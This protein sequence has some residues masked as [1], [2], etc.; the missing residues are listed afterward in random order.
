M[1]AIAMPNAVR[2]SSTATREHGAKP[3]P[4][5]DRDGIP[6]H[7]HGHPPGEGDALR[8][9]P[10]HRRTSTATPGSSRRSAR[11]SR[12]SASTATARPTSR[13]TLLTSGPGLVHLGPERPQPRRP[14]DP[15]GQ[16]AVRASGAT[17]STRTRWSR[18][19]CPGRSSRRPTRSTR[20]ASTTTRSRTWPR[21][22]GS[23]PT[24]RWS[25]ATCPAAARTP[26]P[27]PRKNMSCIACHSSWNPSC[28]GCH[29][30]QKA[31]KKMP[32]L[33]NEGDV[34]RNYVSYNFQT[35]RDDV[36]MLARDG[37]VTGNRIGP[38]RSSCAI[39]V[40]S[41]NANRESIYVQQQ[42][43]SAEGLSGIAFST[44]VPHT[45]RGG[46]TRDQGGPDKGRAVAPEAYLPGRNETKQCT[47]CHVSNDN[48]NN[49]IMAQ[50]LMQGTNY[51]NFIGRY[52]WVAAGEH[53]LAR[54]RRHRARRAAGGHRQ[55]AAPARLPRRLQE[56]RRAR[57]APRARPRAPRARHRRGAR[58]SATASPR[59]S[60]SRPAASTSTPP[61]ARTACG[62]ST[63]PSSTTRGSPSG[64]PPRRSRRW[65]SGSSSGPK[66]ATAV[67]APDD[68]RPRPDPDPPRRE[69]RADGPR[70]VRLPLRRRPRGGAD[71]RPGRHAPRRQPAE[72]LPR[73]RGHVQPRRHPPRGQQHHD[74][75]DLRLHHLRRRPGR[76]RR[77]TTPSN[78]RV[79][80]VIGER[81]SSTSPGPS[82]SS[83]ATATSA[84]RRGSRSS[85]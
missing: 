49:A 61:A 44:N 30:P 8:R 72:Q 34:S 7:L 35:L 13:P 64:S 80:S 58:R 82:R 15:L 55:H 37:D 4:P 28:F 6:V 52:C 83:S 81:R 33:H 26:A 20:R 43:I 48:D 45:V 84:T 77:S 85:T 68:R 78:P 21:P 12:S 24:A 23:T 75:R 38:A 14:A 47:D 53:G 5:P 65:A 25:G 50:L 54:G 62:S 39:H 74:R 18:R 79:T 3:A 1:A 60:T 36:F 32:A 16:A 51:V 22:S 31:N 67:A 71:H 63:S 59:S 2:R 56:A 42:T 76:R 19:T 66:Y 73:A 40:G 46:P 41:Y 27:T 70:D 57:R 29:L 17:S 69:P 11:R 9:L 10:L